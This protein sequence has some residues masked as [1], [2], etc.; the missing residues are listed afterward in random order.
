MSSNEVLTTRRPRRRSTRRGTIASALLAVVLTV[1]GLTVAA[2][3]ANAVVVGAC[4]IKANNPHASGHVTGRINSEGSLR[5]T[6]GM[7]EI[8]V[9]AYLEKSGGSSWAG[10]PQGYL[11]TPAGYTYSSFANTSC[12]QA[13]GTFRT[14][15]SYAF[16]SPP[17]VN[18]SYSANTIYSPW[19]GL[20]CGAARV[21]PHSPGGATSEW[22]SEKPLPEG[23][24]LKST[25]DGAELTFTIGQ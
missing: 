5:C 12:S 10:N 20:L 11:N 6:I 14:R 13:P 21:A 23:I 1:T 2:A 8:Y 7:T 24:T 18:P 4:T 15:V 25:A 22:T 3:P 9:R 16:Q 19:T 17:G